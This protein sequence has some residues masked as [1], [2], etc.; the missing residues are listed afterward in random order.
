MSRLIDAYGEGLLEKDEFEPR[1]REARE[2]LARLESEAAATAKRETEEADF[3]TA[4]EQLEA[5]A[6]RVGDGL[7][8]ADWETRRAILRALIK[9]VEVGKEAIRVVYKVSPNPFDQGPDRGRSQDCGRSAHPPLWCFGGFFS[10]ALRG[11]S[12]SPLPCGED[13]LRHGSGVR[14]T[15]L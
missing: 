6:Q 9:Q 7:Q 14:W 8:E 1:I 10:P 4:V 15:I 13:F 2:R 3:A 12:I 11:K 5:F